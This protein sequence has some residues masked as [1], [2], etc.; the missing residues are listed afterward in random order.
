MKTTNATQQIQSSQ[1]STATPR[2]YSRRPGS[3][4]LIVIGTLALIA[5]FAIVYLSIGRTDRRTASAVR[6]NK[7]QKNSSVAF[8]EYLSTWIGRDRLDAYPAYD[9]A[10]NSFGL[11][12]VTDAPYTDWSRRSES[13]LGDGSDLFTVIGGP[14]SMGNL[15]ADSDFRVASDPWLASTTPVYLGHPGDLGLERPFSNYE[16][17]DAR[18][19]NTKNFLDNRDWLQISNFAPDGRFVNLFNLRPTE[20]FNDNRVFGGF[21]AEPGTGVTI[22]P[23]TERQTRRMSEY[24]SLL[25]KV[26]QADANSL[27]RTFDPTFEGIW[28]PGVN[29]PVPGIVAAADI[30]NTPAVWTMYQ[31]FMYMP[32]NQPFITLNRDSEISTWADPDYPAYQY[33]DADGDGFADARWFELTAARSAN[34]GSSSNPRD[35]IEVMYDNERYRYFI[36]ARAVDL[37]SMVNV[38]T[39][40]DL[41]VAPTID[42]PLGLTPADVDLRR[43]LT[44]QDQASDYTSFGHAFPLSLNQIHRPFRREA[45]N[46]PIWGLWDQP[47]ADRDFVRNVNDYWLYQQDFVGGA[48]L[49]TLADN[50]PAML[51][52]RFAYDALRQGIVLGGSLDPEY[53]GFSDASSYTP[54]ERRF[55]REYE[56]NPMS[57]DG[58]PFEQIN[59]KRR[60]EQ[61]R[62]VAQLDPTETG[63]SWSRDSDYGSGLYGLED[64]TELLTFHGLNDPSTTSRL[65]RVTQGRYESDS[66]DELQTRR[67]GPLMSNRPLSLSRDQHGLAVNDLLTDR[68]DLRPHVGAPNYRSVNGRI[69]F[70]SMAQ[71][72]LSP[73]YRMTTLSGSVGLIPSQRVTD[74]SIL[75]SLTLDSAPLPMLVDTRLGS[76]EVS[77]LAMPNELFDAYASA[78]AGEL[79]SNL[80]FWPTPVDSLPDNQASTLFY[81]HR[82]PELALRIAAHAALNMKDMTD[83]DGDPS[84]ATLFVDNAR[85]DTLRAQ[86]NSGLANPSTDAWY[87]LYPGAADGNLFDL[88]PIGT[89]PA[90]EKLANG[91]LPDQRQVVNIYGFEAMPVLT[92]VSV[93]YAYTDAP[94]L[95]DGRGDPDW[96]TTPGPGNEVRIDFNTGEPDYPDP[97]NI[98][99]VTINPTQA[100]DN[101]DY[102][103]QVLA[104]QLHNPYG[105]AISLGGTGFENRDPLTRQVEF[106]DPTAIDDQSNYSF[107]Y[108]IEYAGRFYKIAQ[109]LEWYPTDQAAVGVHYYDKDDPTLGNNERYSTVAHP[110]DTI[111]QGS[112]TT[113]RMDHG[114]TVSTDGP[115]AFGSQAEYSDFITRN[116]VLQPQ[117]TRVFYVIADKRFDNIV[118]T[119][120]GEGIG[121]DDRWI[122]S[123]TAYG[124]LP[125]GFNQSNLINNDADLDGL[126]DGRVDAFGWTGPAEEFVSNQFRVRGGKAPVMM[127]EFDPRDGKLVNETV[128]AG[129]IEDPT[130]AAPNPITSRNDIDEVRLWKKIVTPLEERDI[131]ETPPAGQTFTYRNLIENDMLVDRMT[132]PGGLTKS[133]NTIDDEID[134]TISFQER[135]SFPPSINGT[136]IRSDNTGLTYAQWK[137]VRRADSVDNTAPGLGEVAPWMLRS[138]GTPTDT[139]VEHETLLSDNPRA[140]DFLIGTGPIDDPETDIDGPTADFETHR[141]LRDFFDHSTQTN[142]N[143]IIQTIAESPWNKNFVDGSSGGA[144]INEDDAGNDTV[145]K[146]VPKV[147]TVTGTALDTASGNKP[148]PLIYTSGNHILKAPRLGDLLLP[149]GIGPTYSP[150][151]TRAANTAEYVATEWMTGPEAMAIAM[152]IDVNP[153]PTDNLA[154]SIWRDPYN[155]T[156]KDFLLDDGHLVI[157]NFVA[158]LN[159]TIEAPPEFTPGSDIHRGTGVPIALGVI[160]HV[161]AIAPIHRVGRPQPTDFEPRITEDEILDLFPELTL[162]RPTFGTININTAPIEVLRLLPGLTPSRASYNG[163]SGTGAEWWG[164][165]LF[166]MNLPKLDLIDADQNPDVAAAIVAYRD[167]TY[168]VPI[169]GSRKEMY[170]AFLYNDA[171]MNFSPTFDPTTSEQSLIGQNFIGATPFGT[172]P[173]SN[174]RG[175]DRQT[176]TGIDG[177]RPTPG[178]GSLGELLAVRIDPA[179]GDTSIATGDEQERWEMLKH[180]SIQQY[181]FDEIPSGIAGQNTI[182]SQVFSGNLTGTNIDD[183]AEKI[184]MANAVLNTLSVRSD[185]FAVWFVVHGYQESDVKNLRPQDPLV[186]TIQKRYL[187]VVDRTNVIKPGDKPKILVLKEVP[188]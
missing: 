166:S 139:R 31:R 44:M 75:E 140:S 1:G 154:V 172:I 27:L 16:A 127:A 9:G 21:N 23:T 86:I 25:R 124:D 181:G 95:N 93:L 29:T 148:A 67:M 121:P 24:L 114:T 42:E 94:A 82:G 28:V 120:A 170:G 58:D 4:L 107:D 113:N 155:T 126:A 138:L 99:P 133:F 43:L 101:D 39:A 19:P 141:R 12:E 11:R 89:L 145:T 136:E 49:R 168:G 186:P 117:E 63:L 74:P 47:R 15:A 3:A 34:A 103:I 36:A 14:F 162:S 79:D 130:V 88:D 68:A 112:T 61:Y 131:D 35:D 69:S 32:I 111:P 122:R 90:D 38:N 60:V 116:V 157:D 55:L 143:K 129:V 115:G 71:V 132:I 22:D 149:W 100:Q 185:Y 54:P 187:M 85:G 59:G 119:P 33:A 73:R 142:R 56:R 48:D 106:D 97:A 20:A 96:N 163:P 50:A 160:D 84:V 175:I 178:F 65:E 147:L 83:A 70:N 109:Y 18:Y 41:L 80:N 146:F 5:V 2:M 46:E 91:S 45:D 52:G 30:P 108:Y 161:R 10:G 7:D 6:S 165:D 104:F 40:T 72:A 102:L 135:Q 158:Y 123:L 8:G 64:L 164:K 152:G 13:V 78:L 171:P 150:D 66:G 176:M 153:N 51:I 77:L 26:D 17:F 159:T 173:A 144:G 156:N 37:S 128:V 98:D 62:A 118:P 81:G 184:S 174:D 125:Q 151:P 183:Y 177:L 137:T 105:H 167:R 180:L 57:L 188:M 92:E 134:N 53:V 76:T 169:S 179:F 87:Q 182:M 110:W